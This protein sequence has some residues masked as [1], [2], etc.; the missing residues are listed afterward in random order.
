MESGSVPF[1]L[2]GHLRLR[3]AWRLSSCYRSRRVGEAV[4]IDNEPLYVS[5]SFTESGRVV[6]SLRDAA[7][8]LEAIE[9]AI[10]TPLA[11]A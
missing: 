9:D 11:T 7:R 6:A 1:D 4:N 10:A 8:W 3:S 2:A 5:H